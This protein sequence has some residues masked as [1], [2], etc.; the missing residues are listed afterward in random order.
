MEAAA[1]EQREL[2]TDFKWFPLAASDSCPR[3]C[4]QESG[5]GIV[6]NQVTGGVLFCPKSTVEKWPALRL[7][8]EV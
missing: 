2:G 4:P 5:R 3:C 6:G 8:S 1:I 7:G